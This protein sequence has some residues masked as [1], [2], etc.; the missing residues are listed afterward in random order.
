M[1]Q[2][3]VH[4]LDRELHGAAALRKQFFQNIIA[5]LQREP[6]AYRHYGVYW[7]RIKQIIKDIG[8]GQEVLHILG[9]YTDRE[10]LERSMRMSEDE[11][12]KAAMAEAAHNARFRPYQRVQTDPETDEEY[13]ILD[14]DLGA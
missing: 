11:F 10:M 12:L 6:L 1:A 5:M 7:W 8:W 2:D 9:D 4:P 13:T 3:S 14:E